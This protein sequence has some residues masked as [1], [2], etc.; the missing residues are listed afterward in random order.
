MPGSAAS[1][2]GLAGPPGAH[3]GA[4]ARAR[5]TR[6]EPPRTSPRS[7]ALRLVGAEQGCGQARDF[8]RRT[9]ADWSLDHCGADALTVVAELLA[10]AVLHAAPHA[11]SHSTARPSSGVEAEIWLKLSLRRPAHL[12]CAVAD[13]SDNLPVYPHTSDPFDEHGRGLRIIDALSEH[14]GWTR[15]QPAGKTVWAMLRTDRQD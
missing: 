13:P 2:A 9:L 7:A 15:C 8:V 12:V 3:P 1:P 4:P 6:P 10:N 11:A 5:L 14:W